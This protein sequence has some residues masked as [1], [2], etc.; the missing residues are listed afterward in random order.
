M[1]SSELF[2]PNPKEGEQ[3]PLFIY[4]MVQIWASDRAESLGVDRA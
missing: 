1:T 3:I 4:F 2:A